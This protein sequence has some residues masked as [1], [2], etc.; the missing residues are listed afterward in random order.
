MLGWVIKQVSTFAQPSATTFGDYD[1]TRS[2]NPT[3]AALEKQVREG[4]LSRVRL[5]CVP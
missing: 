2:G 5:V 1:Y 3:R 4:G